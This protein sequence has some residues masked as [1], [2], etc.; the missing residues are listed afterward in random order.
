[1]VLLYLNYIEENKILRNYMWPWRV[2]QRWC[3]PIVCYKIKWNIIFSKFSP[4]TAPRSKRTFDINNK[5]GA[6]IIN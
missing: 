1:M 2:Y 4:K 6:Q 3:E 5:L